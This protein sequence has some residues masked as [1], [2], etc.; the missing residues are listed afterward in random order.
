MHF[1]FW[2]NIISPHQAPFLRALPD[3]GHKVT[4]VS[5]ETMTR[6]RLLLGWKVPD[7]GK[8]EA[9]I[10]PTSEFIRTL[11]YRDENAVHIMAGA[12]W[13]P[14]G[15]LAARHCRKARRRMGILTEAPDPR[16]IGGLARRAKY[17]LEQFTVGSHYDFV[18]AM[19]EMGVRWF[20]RCG[21]PANRLYPFAYVTDSASSI[22]P[23][24]SSPSRN[25]A[26]LFAG[27][28]LHLKGLD[29]L[30]NAFA[31]I[32][33]VQTQ[34]HLLG[35]GPEKQN[36]RQ[37]ASALGL[38]EKL[39][40]LP[41]TS[42]AEVQ[43]EMGRADVTV[44]PSRKDGWGAVVNESLMAGAPVICS[45]A[46]G[47]A[48]LIREPWLG[49]VFESGNVSKLA[50]ALKHWIQLGPRT[51]AER[52]RIRTWAKCITGQAVALYFVAVMEHIYT[53]A[54]RPT[55]PWREDANVNEAKCAYY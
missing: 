38:S 29:L 13:T 8:A 43:T 51:D 47:A 20:R 50:D 3:L 22:H 52:E 23:Q 16:R 28:F 37:Q 15:T 5:A 24:A 25:V 6:D 4:V 55:A 10:N 53:N 33:S 41:Q 11:V 9:I 31:S 32:A 44:L 26:L 12:R 39:V 14:L 7:L 54:K 40:W 35:D 2:Q 27:R 19:G 49:S 1:V 21:Y 30:I 34:L 36:L 45:S 17:V 46:C 18:F 48:E 42:S